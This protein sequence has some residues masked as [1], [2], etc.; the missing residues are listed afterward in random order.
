MT[1]LRPPAR[2]RPDSAGSR[3]EA[4]IRGVLSPPSPRRPR[5]PRGPPVVSHRARRGAGGGTGRRVA[6]GARA[7]QRTAVNAHAATRAA[8]GMMIPAAVAGLIAFLLIPRPDRS[9]PIS[10]SPG[11]SKPPAEL[12]RMAAAEPL[13]PIVVRGGG[14]GL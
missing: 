1:R 13:H 8:L 7:T 4:G 9:A 14:G 12:A 6:A 5:G 2:P 3:A 11:E 10:I